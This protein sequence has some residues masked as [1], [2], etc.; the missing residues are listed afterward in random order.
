VESAE[1]LTIKAV[2]LEPKERIRL[3]EAILFSLDKSDPEVEKTRI[4][5]SE[6]RF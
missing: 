3:V 1:A 6:A 4:A 2:G 5:E